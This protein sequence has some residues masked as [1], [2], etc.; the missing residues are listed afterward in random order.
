MRAF[1]NLYRQL[2][3]T[4]KTNTKVAALVDYFKVAPPEDAIWAVYFLSGNRPKRVISSRLLSEWVSEK[5]GIPYWLFR[6]SYDAVGDIAETVT[7]ILPDFDSKTDDPLHVWIENRL[8][9]LKDMNEDERRSEIISA[10]YELNRSER[11]IWNKL[12]TGSFRVGVSRKLVTRALAQVAQIDK[13]VMAHRLMGQWQPTVGF[14]QS[15]FASNT[16][17]A[18]KSR[19]YPFFLAYSLENDPQ[20]VL[21]DMQN[22]QIEWK[23]DG[24]RAQ[25][26][27][28]EDETFLWTRGEDLVNNKYPEITNASEKLPNGC[29]ID[30]EL[31]A[32][33]D[34]KVLPFAQ[35]QRRIGR[36]KVSKKILQDIPVILLAYD[37]LEFNGEDIREQAIKDRREILET[38]ITGIG[39]EHFLISELLNNQLTW[40]DLDTIRQESRDR[41]VEG[42][43]LK[44]L[45]SPYRV[46]RVRGDWWKWKVDPY[47]IDAVLL[48]AQKG[49]GKRAS[50]YTDYTFAVWN[51]TGELVPF[52]KAYSGLT[53]EEIRQV[54]NFVRRNVKEKFG[55]VRS[56]TPK[57]V[58]ELAFENIQ[59]STRHKSGIAV[60]FPRIV[61]WR[62]DKEPQ[63][64]DT[65][66]MVEAMLPELS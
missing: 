57:L 35:L 14:Y 7:L 33:K 34:G 52:A 22:W 20:T 5:T 43:M 9:P 21:G 41:M 3:E 28:R 16:N 10:W 44:R 63:D 13:E 29:V 15:L 48:Y 12:L 38:I 61:R 6:E 1:S 27:R 23:W 55:P 30:G 60:R 51:D 26:I 19:P 39:D 42:F 54:D 47:T 11:F 62:K 18:D 49:S 36:K 32:W 66:E 2:D 31:L 37:L 17:D 4:T 53:D 45:D 64:A 25:L 58:F 65:L 46:G 59:R 40:G 24:I 50:L 8:L 56:V